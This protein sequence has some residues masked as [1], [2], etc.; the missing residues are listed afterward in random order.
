[1]KWERER[2]RETDL[3]NL[4]EKPQIFET[5]KEFRKLHLYRKSEAEEI[6]TQDRNGTPWQQG[7]GKSGENNKE[8]GEGDEAERVRCSS[9]GS[10]HG[11]NQK[12]KGTGV[13]WEKN[14][15]HSI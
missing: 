2:G 6:H 4:D 13:E 7:R 8:N 3:N 10:R 9:K 12:E 14:K 5:G 11:R 15:E 1:M